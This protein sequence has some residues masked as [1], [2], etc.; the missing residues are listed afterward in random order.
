MADPEFVRRERSL[1][2]RDRLTLEHIPGSKSGYR[3]MLFAV[4]GVNGSDLLDRA[5]Q[6]L[7]RVRSGGDHAAIRLDHSN[8]RNFEMFISGVVPETELAPRL[9]PRFTLDSNTRTVFFAARAV[10]FKPITL[11]KVLDNKTFF[12]IVLFGGISVAR[13]IRFQ[14][15]LGIGGGSLSY[16]RLYTGPG[17]HRGGKGNRR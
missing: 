16:S 14:S 1:D 3:D 11:L 12:R 10:I 4:I 13:S 7:Y 9:H 5:G 6:F 17:E 2:D 15:P 8:V